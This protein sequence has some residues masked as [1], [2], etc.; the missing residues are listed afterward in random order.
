MTEFQETQVGLQVVVGRDS[1]QNEVEGA[2]LLLHFRGGR[3][4]VAVRLQLLHTTLLL[5]RPK[6]LNYEYLVFMNTHIFEIFQGNHNPHNKMR[7][8]RH[9]KVM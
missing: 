1:V 9:S 6:L 4:D 8:S 3:V 2:G 7:I 5:C